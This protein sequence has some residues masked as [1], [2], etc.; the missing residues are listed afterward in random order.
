[1]L[2]LITVIMS[3]SLWPQAAHE[4]WHRSQYGGMSAVKTDW[5]DTEK[6][7]ILK[8]IIYSL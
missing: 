5:T 6:H 8:M 4:R 3:T 1:M 7:K 2:E